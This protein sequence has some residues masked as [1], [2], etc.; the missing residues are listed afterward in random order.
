MLPPKLLPL[1]GAAFNATCKKT[2]AYSRTVTSTGGVVKV[3]LVLAHQD[4]ALTCQHVF[5]ESIVASVI[6]RL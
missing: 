2:R 6:T 1:S 5:H 4:G 3:T